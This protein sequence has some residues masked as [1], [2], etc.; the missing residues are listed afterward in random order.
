MPD[1]NT[2]TN[3]AAPQ[4][5]REAVRSNIDDSAV[6]AY[7]AQFNEENS[8]DAETQENEGEA[9]PSSEGARPSDADADVTTKEGESEATPP[10]GEG[11]DEEPPLE[12]M[13]L[14]LSDLEPEAR[15]RVVAFAK[16]QDRT[17]QRTMRENAELRRG[18]GQSPPEDDAS[19]ALPSDDE[20]LESIGIAKDDPLRDV[21]AGVALPLLKQQR[22]L[23]QQVN[24][25][26]EDRTVD[27]AALLWEQRLSA[28]EKDEG[29][30]P[31]GW[32]ELVAFAGERGITDPDQ[33]YHTYMGPIKAATSKKVNEER[34]AAIEA[35]KKKQAGGVRPRSNA[36]TKPG[37]I[38]ADNT[39]DAVK[40]AMA[41]IEAEQGI[42]WR[43]LGV[44]VS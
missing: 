36:D 9:A 43:A 25:L 31:I 23:S 14:D 2:G 33:A 19:A 8:G 37:P 12:Y 34:K 20:L 35:L 7:L 16:E 11:T 32:D 41:Q 15:A 27:M 3:D 10:A 26:V 4:S 44:E 6:D 40:Q 28:L 30:L 29:E 39:K 21:M 17:I 1:E 18:D 22:A 42:D 24:K 13:G 5:L 38:T